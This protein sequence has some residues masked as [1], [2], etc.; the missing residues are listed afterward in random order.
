MYTD[1]ETT[2]ACLSSTGRRNSLVL[3]LVLPKEKLE[4]VVVVT[5]PMPE[6]VVAAPAPKTPP[7]L[8]EVPGSFPNIELVTGVPKVLAVPLPENAVFVAAEG[9]PKPNL[10]LAMLAAGAAPNP[11]KAG[12][13]PEGGAPKPPNAG[14]AEVAAP[15]PPEACKVVLA[16]S[17]NSKPA[18]AGAESG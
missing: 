10:V 6:L 3:L 18:G 14:A 17:L 9:A 12:A 1:Q 11:P 2:S 7:A 13:D 16:L 5:V 15:K 8:P 4:A